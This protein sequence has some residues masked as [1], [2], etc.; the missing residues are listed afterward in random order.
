[1][2]T[3]ALLNLLFLNREIN[4]ISGSIRSRK[5]YIYIYIYGNNPGANQENYL[6]DH[7]LSTLQTALGF[8]W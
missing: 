2:L 6:Q 3:K 7:S 5:K 4:I 8:I 1:M